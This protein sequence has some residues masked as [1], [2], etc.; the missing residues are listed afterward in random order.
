VASRSCLK[1]KPVRW[2]TPGTILATVSWLVSSFVFSF[3]L[4]HLG[5]TS[6]TYGAFAGVAI[7]LLWMFITAVSVLMGAELDSVL[8]QM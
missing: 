5:H 4:D 3:Y 8:G 6:R 2:I 7:L 1:P